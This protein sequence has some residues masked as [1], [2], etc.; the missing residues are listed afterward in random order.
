MKGLHDADKFISFADEKVGDRAQDGGFMNFGIYIWSSTG[1]NEVAWGYK[2]QIEEGVLKDEG[3][4]GV[5]VG[6]GC[7]VRVVLQKE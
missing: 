3:E 2:I 1:S 4:V 5:D 7:S 6:T